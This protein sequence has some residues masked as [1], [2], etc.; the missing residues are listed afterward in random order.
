MKS[1]DAKLNARNYHFDHFRW[2]RF[3]FGRFQPSEIAN[4]PKL[5]FIVSENSKMADYDEAQISL[6]MFSRKI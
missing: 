2:P 6:K 4:V 3:D 5:K 1:I